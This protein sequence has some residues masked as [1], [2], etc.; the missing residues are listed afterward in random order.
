MTDARYTALVLAAARGG[1]RDPLAVAGNVSHKAFIDIAGTPMLRRTVSSVLDCGRVGRVI[2]SIED[3][4]RAA[5]EEILRPLGASDRIVFV[6]STDT[7]GASVAATTEQYPD[8]LPLIITTADN[9]LHTPEMVRFFCDAL[10]D[11]DADGAFG[12]TPAQY[13]LD[14]YP[15]ESRAFHRFS[16]GAFSSCNLYA[17]LTPR[18]LKAP[19]T[20]NSGGQFGKKP[21]RL[22]FSFGMIAFL[23]YKSRRAKLRTFLSF[24]SRAIGV[25]TE[26]VFMPFAEGPIDVDRMQDWELANRIISEREGATVSGN[27]RN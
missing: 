23:V 2:V 7:I 20:F 21:W 25:R 16:D 8:S 14:K 11:V 10:D 22:I 9:A 4:S 6:S 27:A 13:I 3:D 26:P 15:G 19:R 5:A 1:P 17:L 24:L 18:S 12:L